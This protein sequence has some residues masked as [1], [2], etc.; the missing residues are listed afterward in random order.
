MQKKLFIFVLVFLAL[1]LSAC[2]SK[3]NST[4]AKENQNE[5]TEQANKAADNG[6]AEEAKEDE[7]GKVIEAPNL[8]EDAQSLLSYTPGMFSGT[9]YDDDETAIEEELSKLPALKEEDGEEEVKKYW[10]KLIS[11]FAEDYPDPNEVVENW[12]KEDFGNPEIG[13]PRYEFKEQYNVEIIL[14]ASG[15]MAETIDGKSMMEWAKESIRTFSANLPKEAN[16]ALRVYGHKGTG[17][18][19]DK[20]LSC[21]SSELLYEMQS[22]DDAKLNEA[23]NQFQPSGWTPIAESL[24]QAKK[25]FAKFNGDKN[26]NIIY[27]VSDGVETCD[28]DP[29]KAANELAASSVAPILNVIGFNVDSEGQTELKKIAEAADGTYSTVR[30]VEQLQAEFDRSQEMATKWLD[31]KINAESQNIDTVLAREE[32]IFEYKNEFADK[33]S[34]EIRNLDKAIL[35]LYKNDQIST[36][37]REIFKTLRHA[38]YDLTNKTENELYN[39]LLKLAQESYKEIEKEINEKYKQGS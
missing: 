22:Y 7:A 3:D 31:W 10:A 9:F 37:Q 39:D 23:L 11:L 38:R 25:D 36:D 20:K 1:T 35:F 5:S 24:I 17:S 27:L 21:S 19:S 16:V 14:D 15:S 4:E 8:P 28:G 32:T 13:D 29:V 18:D 12:K 26:T 2:S 6:E 30:N 33:S 34:L